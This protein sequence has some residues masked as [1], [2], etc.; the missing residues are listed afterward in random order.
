MHIIYNCAFKIPDI[1]YISDGSRLEVPM[2]VVVVLFFFI[3]DHE[4]DSHAENKNP[5]RKKCMIN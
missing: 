3:V 4:M 5:S 2:V 1:K